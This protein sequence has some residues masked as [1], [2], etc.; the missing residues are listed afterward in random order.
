[1]KAI[2]VTRA[3]GPEM[4][5]LGEFP[6][7]QPHD[8]ELLI[9]VEAVGL[10]FADL[11]GMQGNYSGGPP[12]PY[13]PG[14]EFAGL[15]VTTGRL[16]MGYAEYGALAEQIAAAPARVW[17]VPP[18]FTAV[19]AAAF[20]VN[21]L[22]AFFAFWEAGLV[23]REPDHELRFPGG[24]RPRVLIH[25]VAGGVGTAAVQIGKLLDIEMY[26]T[27]SSDSKIEGAAALGLDHGIVYTRQDY[28]KLIKEQT[29]GE[30]VDAVFEMRGG[31]ETARSIRTMGF[32]G[33]C[34]LYGAASGK[35]AQFDPREL[36]SKAQSV[37]G[38][39]LS[40]L[41]SRPEPM[42]K[43]FDYLARWVA[44]GKLKPVI[45]QTLPMEQTIAGYKLLQEG[46]NF[47]KV[48]VKIKE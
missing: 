24:R 20:P 3:G 16:V 2:M 25:A 30:G 33:R 23:E 1:M 4:L 46:K 21:F 43:A 17:P 15:E 38:L 31:E 18:Q 47:G 19:Q 42:R 11:L 14:R 35:P 34:I 29:R 44:D 41:A 6:P 22:T 39:W 7:P 36:Y 27:A 12:P 13:V 26:G 9:R 48:V 45:G 10:N 5:E 37:W 40:R 32:L 8:G 28:Q